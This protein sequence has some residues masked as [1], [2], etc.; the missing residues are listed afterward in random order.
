M[1]RAAQ[2]AEIGGGHRLGKERHLAHA[3]SPW[4]YQAGTVSPP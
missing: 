4:T 2:E 3:N 1:R